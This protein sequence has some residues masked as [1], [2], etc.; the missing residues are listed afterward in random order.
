MVKTYKIFFWLVVFGLFNNLGASSGK[1]PLPTRKAKGCGVLSPYTRLA[2]A[3]IAIRFASP[4]APTTPAAL[5]SVG[6]GCGSP[7]ASSPVDVMPQE[8]PGCMF[9]SHY[10]GR[11]ELCDGTCDKTG[12]DLHR[13]YCAGKQEYYG[14]RVGCR[15]SYFNNAFI[16]R[17]AA[18]EHE[19]ETGHTIFNLDPLTR[20]PK[21]R[22]LNRSLGIVTS[23]T[24]PASPE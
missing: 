11:K 5:A 24:S 6:F 20:E 23:P 3:G 12:D 18:L 2:G 15:H 17:G 16:H 21:K 4:V 10:E 7:I 14:V 22:E 8:W 1:P 9:T 13:Y 19:S